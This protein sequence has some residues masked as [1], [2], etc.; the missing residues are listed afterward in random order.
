MPSDADLVARLRRLCLALPA[1]S[2]TAAF[3]HPNWRVG[4]KTFAVFEHYHG[5][6]CICFKTT[7]LE[8]QALI[9][10]PR[11]F[12]APYVGRHGWVS[13][14]VDMGLDWEEVRQFVVQS[15]RAVA[16]PRLLR[17]PRG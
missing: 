2:E 12:P 10:E 11:F 17:K 7:F 14:D 5:R 6:R 1:T 16:P 8:Q 4:K 3:G 13:L 9:Q 15:H